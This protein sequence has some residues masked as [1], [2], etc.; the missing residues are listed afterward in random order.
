MHS[1]PLINTSS[2]QQ[3]VIGDS[4]DDYDAADTLFKLGD[5]MRQLRALEREDEALREK[6]NEMGEETDT[7]NYQSYLANQTYYDDYK[8]VNYRFVDFGNVNDEPFIIE[9]DRTVGKGGFVWDAGFILA[10]HVISEREWQS[11][12]PVKVIEVGAGTGVAGL[13]VAKSCATASVH[14]T[15]LPQLQPLLEKNAGK[16]ASTGVLEWGKN[17]NMDKYDVI[18]GA[19]VV[20]SIYD[21]TGL[22]RTIYDLAK[23]DSRVYLACRDRLAGNVE[24]FEA[25]MKQYFTIVERRKAESQNKSP[26]VWIMFATGK[27]ENQ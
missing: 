15:D 14:L 19:D 24:R 2:V 21:S 8:H 12:K 1:T 13:M 6:E 23:V 18:L 27:R 22:A 25:Y 9:Q 4:D 3:Q 7:L 20:A 26:N 11:E 16:D 10:Q 5:R 17:N